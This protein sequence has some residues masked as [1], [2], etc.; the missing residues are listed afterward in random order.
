V[1]IGRDGAFQPKIANQEPGLEAELIRD[2]P[3]GGSIGLPY[4]AFVAGEG[5]LGD[6]GL[7]GESLLCHCGRA[8]GGDDNVAGAGNQLAPV[9]V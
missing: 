3:G 6:P 9:S 5:S 4:A 2:A 8:P 7:F 1:N